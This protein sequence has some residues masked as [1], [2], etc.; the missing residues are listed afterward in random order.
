MQNYLHGNILFQSAQLDPR[1]GRQNGAEL[2]TIQH[3]LKLAHQGGVDVLQVVALVELIQVVALLVKVG[4]LEL[5]A[6]PKR[7]VTAV[8]E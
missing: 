6:E 4:V 2:I 3:L 1:H 7:S 5:L 8:I